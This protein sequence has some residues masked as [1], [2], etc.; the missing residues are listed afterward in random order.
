MKISYSIV[1]ISYSK[2][3]F[4]YSGCIFFQENTL[5]V[6]TK[7]VTIDVVDTRFYVNTRPFVSQIQSWTTYVNRGDS[8]TV[9]ESYTCMVNKQQSIGP[10]LYHK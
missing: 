5:L 8:L 6:Y 10:Y 3:R 9:N 1:S 4:L 7:I 2:E